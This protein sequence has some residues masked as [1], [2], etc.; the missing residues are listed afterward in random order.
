MRKIIM[1]LYILASSLIANSLLAVTSSDTKVTKQVFFDITIDGKPAGRIIFGLFGDVTPKT[2]ENFRSLAKGDKGKP[3]SY[4]DTCFH[5]II[6]NFMIQGGDTTNFNGTGGE[7]IYG[8]KFDDENFTLKHTDAGMLS[9]A[10]AGPNTNSSQFFITTVKTPWLDGKHVV[11][12]KVTSGMELVQ[13]IEA[14]GSSDGTPSAQ[15][16]ISNSGE[17]QK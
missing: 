9:M 15:V 17:L 14:L 4:K 11:F 12:G 1:M 16:C 6:P 2:V 10:N 3:L 8:S 7:S 13:K 5:R